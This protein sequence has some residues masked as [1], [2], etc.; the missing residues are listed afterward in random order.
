MF[1]S[2]LFEYFKSPGTAN[3]I[4]QESSFLVRPLINKPTLSPDSAKS[5]CFLNV[6]IPVIALLYD[7]P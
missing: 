7:L 1:A 2:A 3:I 5:I 6:S 4:P